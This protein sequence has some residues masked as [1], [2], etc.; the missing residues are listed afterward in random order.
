MN[1][2]V[3][4]IS[5]PVK[6]V[7]SLRQA[8]HRMAIAETT[9]RYDVLVNGEVKGE[10]YYNTRGYVG[11]LPLPNGKSLCMPEGSINRFLAEIRR[12]NLEA[13]MKKASA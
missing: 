12:I 8:P 7:V 1:Q 9:M 5:E 11:N 13:K 2:T 10:L 3:S 6:H 4:T